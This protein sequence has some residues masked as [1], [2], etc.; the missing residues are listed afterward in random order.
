MRIHDDEWHHRSPFLSSRF[1]SIAARGLDYAGRRVGRARRDRPWSDFFYKVIPTA[2]PSA[3]MPGEREGGEG[4]ETANS[5]LFYPA[6]RK[7]SIARAVSDKKKDI[8]WRG[9]FIG[10]SSI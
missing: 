3:S 6:I 8:R 2:K 7:R 1:R 4:G 10:L 9:R 5:R